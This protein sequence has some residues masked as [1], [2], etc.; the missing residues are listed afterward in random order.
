MADEDHPSTRL[1]TYSRDAMSAVGDR[2]YRHL[3]DFTHAKCHCIGLPIEHVGANVR[4]VLQRQQFA[5]PA[6]VSNDSPFTLAQLNYR[7]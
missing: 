4:I 7:S 3:D 2:T 5:E 6:E 1:V